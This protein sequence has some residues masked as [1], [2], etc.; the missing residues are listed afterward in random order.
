[1]DILGISEMCWTGNAHLISDGKTILYFEH[2]KRRMHGVG[3]ILKK[4]AVKA[5]IGWTPIN[6][7]ILT[8]RF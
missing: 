7:R 8:V 2:D 3:L 6:D 4:Q 5:L 1:M